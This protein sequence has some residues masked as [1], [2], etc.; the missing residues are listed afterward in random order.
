M[1][2]KSKEERKKA[3]EISR[4]VKHHELS[5]DPNF[6]PEFA[7]AMYLPNKD[8]SKFPSIFRFLERFGRLK[9]IKRV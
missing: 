3:E 4:K 5:V 7:R 1:I 6:A 8:P 9:S 2:L